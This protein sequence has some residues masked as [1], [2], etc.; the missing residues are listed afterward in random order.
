VFSLSVRFP[1]VSG[2]LRRRVRRASPGKTQHLPIS[3]PASVRS[4][5][6]QASL[7][8]AS[9][10]TSSPLPYSPAKGGIRYVHRFCLMLPSDGPFLVPALASLALPFRP[11]TAGDFT[12]SLSTRRPASAS[13][14]AHIQSPL[15]QPG[16][17]SGL[18][19]S[20]TTQSIYYKSRGF[21][22]YIIM[23]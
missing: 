13:C 23:F 20:L 12:S 2:S 5:G 16:G 19:K 10:T 14:Q 1:N 6:Y 9:S 15:A 21:D 8:H 3:R 7:S 18:I 17:Y 11:V 4:T 22:G